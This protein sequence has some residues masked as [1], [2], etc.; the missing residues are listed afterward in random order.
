L[1]AALPASPPFGLAALRGKAAHKP[2][3]P[4]PSKSTNI[5]WNKRELGAFWGAPVFINNLYPPF[6][7]QKA[8]TGCQ[9]IVPVLFHFQNNLILLLIWNKIILCH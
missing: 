7:R 3:H 1:T 9:P 6:F 5:H 2:G 8:F 4:H